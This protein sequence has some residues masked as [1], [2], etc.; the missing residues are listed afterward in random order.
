[1]RYSHTAYAITKI[2]LSYAIN[3]LGNNLGHR[4]VD[5]QLQLDPEVAIA[6]GRGGMSDPWRYCA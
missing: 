5:S 1:M 6:L 4:L 3:E 2:D